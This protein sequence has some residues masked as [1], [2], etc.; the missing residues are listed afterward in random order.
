MKGIQ[1]STM[2]I[3][4]IVLGIIVLL[5]FFY[6]ITTSKGQVDVIQYQTA[7]RNCCGDRS[8]Y[9]CSESRDTV[10]CKVPWSDTTMTLEEL[11]IK[12]GVDST[13]LLG[14]CFCPS[15]T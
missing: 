11:R 13:S 7:L 2:A 6:L 15:T 10:Q 12:A 14:F 9:D 4:L 5:A 8:I 1:L 3:I